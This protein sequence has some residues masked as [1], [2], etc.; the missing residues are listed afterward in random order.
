MNIENLKKNILIVWQI[1]W[2]L[3]IANSFWNFQVTIDRMFLGQYSTES[4]AAAIAAVGFFW[5]P[6]AL[7]QQTAAYVT[8]FVAQ[9]TGA[10]KPDRIGPS[11]WH[12]VY[13]SMIGGGLFLLL[14]PASHTIFGW[15]GHSE[16]I[17]D[18]EIQYF[19]ALAFSALP[20]ALVAAIS[21]FYTGIGRSRPIMIINGTG[22]VFNVLF[23]YLII[24][25]NFGFP[26]LGIYGAGI[27]T[28]MANALG[29]TVGF[30]MLFKQYGAANF[31]LVKGWRPE[32][33][34]MYRYFRFGVP[35]GMQW[36]LEGLAFTFFL[37]LLGRL[38][39]GD[40]AL[41]ASG[42]TVTIM[43]LAILPVLGVAQGV[44]SL[45]GQNL[46]E[47]NEEGAVQVTW[48]G[49][50]MTIMYMIVMGSSFLMF[51]EFYMGFF[52]GSANPELW[53]EVAQMVPYLLMF[54]T[55]FIVFDGLNLIFSFTLKGAGDTHFVSMVALL[56]PWPIMVLPS[57]YVSDWNNGV[58]WAWAA[59][60]LFISLQGLIFLLRFLQ[61]RWKKMR[62][63]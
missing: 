31:N 15:M 63:I 6:M 17:M 28:A 8:T 23:D 58:Y 10:K 27:A 48:A 59:A 41:A 36:A 1:S 43:M 49:V 50:S 62:V 53:N 55:V 54:V 9:Y 51:P 11:V 35:S 25:G 5:G 45:V 7:V 44:A 22:L 40:S 47:N 29:A 21:G 57:W 46:G 38:P 2:P 16:K 20:T 32:K 14:I 3:I 42:I 4:L 60:S 61:G 30:I 52:A 18:L 37:A 39:N 26:E 24:F 12:S 19:S 13:V 56:L 33:D 34:L